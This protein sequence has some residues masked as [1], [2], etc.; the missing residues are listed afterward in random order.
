[1]GG[2]PSWRRRTP[3]EVF[4]HLQKRGVLKNTSKSCRPASKCDFWR[5]AKE[6]RPVCGYKIILKRRGPD[7]TSKSRP[8]QPAL[9]RGPALQR[10][11]LLSLPHLSR[12]N[13]SRHRSGRFYTAPSAS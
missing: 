8:R 1:M 7:D 11:A 10:G 4:K 2:S 9:Y 12:P 13:S 3:P 5:C 6:V